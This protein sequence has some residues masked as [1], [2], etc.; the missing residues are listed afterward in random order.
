MNAWSTG[1]AGMQAMVRLAKV[2]ALLWVFL[3]FVQQ[4][5]I[6]ES[7]PI[8]FAVMCGFGS[9]AAVMFSLSTLLLTVVGDAHPQ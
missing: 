1:G 6:C 5:V 8:V 7:L 2:E 9:T 3:A 4:T